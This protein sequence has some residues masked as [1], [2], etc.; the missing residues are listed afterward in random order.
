MGMSKE[1]ETLRR[2]NEGDGKIVI[3]E[4]ISRESI[5]FGSGFQLS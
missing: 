4:C 2:C 1:D 5:F 3:L